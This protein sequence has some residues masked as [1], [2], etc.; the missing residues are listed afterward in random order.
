MDAMPFDNASFD[1]IW[2]EGAVYIMGFENA[3][4]TFRPLLK[5]KGCIAISEICWFTDTR[6]NEFERFWNDNYS[7]MKTQKQKIRDIE[8]VGYELIDSFKLP[9]HCWITNYYEPIE[10]IIPDY[11]SKYKNSSEA[12][13]MVEEHKNEFELY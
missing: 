6:P 2:S 11:L 4:K 12:L 9:Q 7:E 5:N 1:L 13:A 10:K 8:N 3:L